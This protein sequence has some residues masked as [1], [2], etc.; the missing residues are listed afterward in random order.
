MDS[1]VPPRYIQYLARH[2]NISMT[3][4]YSHQYDEH[5]HEFVNN[6]RI[7]SGQKRRQKRRQDD[8]E[9]V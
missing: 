8:G 5:M 7:F 9:D 1:G 6:F 3:D 2:A 4:S